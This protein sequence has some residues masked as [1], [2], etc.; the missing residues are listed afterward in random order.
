MEIHHPGKEV[1]LKKME[2]WKGGNKAGSSTETLDGQGV[3][4]PP[5]S[6][7]VTVGKPHPSVSPSVKLSG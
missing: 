3:R 4:R 7:W 2:T 1:E 5:A 6:H